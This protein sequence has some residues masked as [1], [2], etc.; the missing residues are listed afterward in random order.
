MD[1]LKA[2]IFLFSTYG[3]DGI[4]VDQIVARAGCNKRMLYHYFGNKGGLYVAVLKEAFTKL[5]EIEIESLKSEDNLKEALIGLIC[6]YFDFLEENREF[7]RLLMWENLSEARFISKHPE[8][9]SKSKVLGELKRI[10]ARNKISFCPRHLLI[11]LYSI[12]YIYYSNRFTLSYTI[13]LD[14]KDPKVRRKG[15]LQAANIMIEGLR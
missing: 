15:V 4:S 10:L 6:R 14:L 8:L 1:I 3:Y 9:L 2:G 13:G 11:Q 5:E 12:C 7:F